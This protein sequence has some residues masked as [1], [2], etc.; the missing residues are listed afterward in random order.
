MGFSKKITEVGCHSR[1]SS[2]TPQGSNPGLLHC[3]QILYH[4]GH[5]GHGEDEKA[6]SELPNSV[7]RA[8][9]VLLTE[10]RRTGQLH[11]MAGVSQ[12]ALPK[13]CCENQL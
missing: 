8:K 5:Q 4:L 12:L 3:R 7:T 2:P 11:L 1:G 9:I 10:V 13:R 6:N